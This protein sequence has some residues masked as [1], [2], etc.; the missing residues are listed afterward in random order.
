MLGEGFLIRNGKICKNRDFFLRDT[1]QNVKHIIS[2][3]IIR[4]SFAK[5]YFIR[6]N[7]YDSHQGKGHAFATGV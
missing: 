5:K 6:E 7:M 2:S 1:S 4:K 3:S